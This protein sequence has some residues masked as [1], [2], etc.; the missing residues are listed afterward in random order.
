MLT[1]AGLLFQTSPCPVLPGTRSK[2]LSHSHWTDNTRFPYLVRLCRGYSRHENSIMKLKFGWLRRSQ[3]L[4]LLYFQIMLCRLTFCD[5]SAG[6]GTSQ[7][8]TLQ[9][10]NECNFY[11]PRDP[12]VSAFDWLFNLHT[13][14]GWSLWG[15][16]LKHDRRVPAFVQLASL[17]AFCLQ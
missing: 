17:C 16:L 5:C 6:S 1:Q 2:W 9:L 15:R 10:M 7:V 11:L 14:F 12:R 8:F 13:I 3:Q 4:L